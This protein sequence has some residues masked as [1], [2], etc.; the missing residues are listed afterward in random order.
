MLTAFVFSRLQAESTSTLNA[1]IIGV[2]MNLRAI[3]LIMGFT[4]LGTE[5][6]NPKI[7]LFFAKTYFKQ[8]PLALE[9]SLDSLPAMIANTPEVGKILKHP[10]MVVQH[11]INY[12]ENRLAEI[13]TTQISNQN[14]YIVTGN[15][16]A[17][18]TSTILEI[19]SKLK[20]EN[21]KVEGIVTT[22]ILENEITA[23]YDVLNISTRE[24][25]RFLRTFGDDIQQ[26]IGK[27]FIYDEGLKL[28]ENSL[29]NSNTKLFV[30]D[31][32][33]KLE[34]EEKGW[35]KLLLQVISHSKSNLL[36]SVRLEVI[37]EVLEK[38]NI[39]PKYIFN[40]SEQKGDELFLMLQK[41]FRIEK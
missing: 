32:I 40:V 14:I 25:V 33:G 7:R 31:E 39:S 17:G 26:R 10:E 22:R 21:I 37:N 36:L 13:R 6:Y 35:H 1:V 30:I 15:I 4:V 24:K 34:L 20:M 41:D 12:A 8:L 11:L 23:G 19:V 29:N 16:E 9:L 5:L 2:E 3:I 27:Y 18:K 28:G 38:Y